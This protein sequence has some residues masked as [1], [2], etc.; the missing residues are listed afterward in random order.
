MSPFE[1]YPYI[2]EELLNYGNCMLTSDLERYSEELNK[3]I[4][5][6]KNKCCMNSHIFGI[7]YTYVPTHLAYSIL[8]KPNQLYIVNSTLHHPLLDSEINP[9]VITNYSFFPLSFN[10]NLIKNKNNHLP[11]YPYEMKN[12]TNYP[13]MKEK[14]RGSFLDLSSADNL[15]CDQDIVEFFMHIFTMATR[16]EICLALFYDSNG[17]YDC[18]FKMYGNAVAECFPKKPIIIISVNSDGKILNMKR[19]SH[20][21]R[22]QLKNEE[23]F[24]FFNYSNFNILLKKGINNIKKTAII[25]FKVLPKFIMDMLCYHSNIPIYAPGASTA[26][27]SECFGKPYIH[28]ILDINYEDRVDEASLQSWQFINRLFSFFDIIILEETKEFC[29]TLS[30]TEFLGYYYTSI[31]TANKPENSPKTNT[32]TIHQLND[33]T[34]LYEFSRSHAQYDKYNTETKCKDYKLSGI[35]SN[36]YIKNMIEENRHVEFCQY[37]CDEVNKLMIYYIKESTEE[38]GVFY[39][40]AKKLQQQALNPDNNMMFNILHDHLN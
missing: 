11:T 16:N 20:I 13:Y 33:I 32:E 9:L 8:V 34:L 37:I 1:K 38:G 26:N 17:V 19:T 31:N 15:S 4:L 14:I 30:Y 36:H 29:S 10:R 25:N 40:L 7:A 27:L 21:I 5:P 18:Q 12:Y 23:S 39:K 28:K 22:E 2:V 24:D 6:I 3:D 35:D